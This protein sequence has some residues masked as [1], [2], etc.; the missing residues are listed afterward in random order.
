MNSKP[1]SKPGNGNGEMFESR[2]ADAD[3]G[4]SVR[5]NMIDLRDF[6]DSEFASTEDDSECPICLGAFDFPI[7]CDDCYREFGGGQ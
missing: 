6:Y 5:C 4:D 3:R 1:D 2:Q 7:M